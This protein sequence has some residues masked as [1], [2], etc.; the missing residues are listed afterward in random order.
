M[1]ACANSVDVAVSMHITA[2]KHFAAT[3]IAAVQLIKHVDT[4]SSFTANAKGQERHAGH[5][6]VTV[7]SRTSSIDQHAK[8][9]MRVAG[10]LLD[11][12]PNGFVQS[13][14]WK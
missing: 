2:V 4:R 9:A 13:L 6:S 5:F 3:E 10:H 1:E 11:S 8:A 7:G 14:I 12:L